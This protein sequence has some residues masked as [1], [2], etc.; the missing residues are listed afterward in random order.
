MAY[1]IDDAQLRLANR[2]GE[3]NAPTVTSE[4]TK[5]RN[6]MIEAAEIIYAKKPFWFMQSIWTDATIANRPNYTFAS[7]LRKEL[8]IY[9]DGYKYE[10]ID[11][12]AIDEIRSEL[13]PVQVLYDTYKYAYYTVGSN[14][15][16]IPTPTSAP[17]AKD[18][19]SITRSGDTATVT[20]TAVHGLITND[21]VT[22]AGANETDYN[23]KYQITY[24]DTTTFTYAVS[25]T[26]TTPATGTLTFTKDNIEVWGIQEFTPYTADTDSIVIPDKFINALVAY[27][28]GRYW[29]T[30]H[31]RGKSSDAFTEFES[32]LDDMDREHTRR[33]FKTGLI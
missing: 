18:I 19:T 5:R 26:P 1:T 15:Y 33:S 11:V 32:I 25:N 23:G 7:D 28:E 22:I 4:A 30:A 10:K 3:S 20:S 29:S 2:L 12:Q 27:A 16:L 13:H 9:V 31:K 24:V 21:Y 6:W 14:Y 8:M 17:T